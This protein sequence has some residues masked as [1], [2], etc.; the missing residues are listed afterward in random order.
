LTVKTKAYLAW[1]AISI[2]WGTTYLVIRI[3]VTEMPPY[4]FSGIRWL[5]AG[6]LFLFAL[7]LKG[8]PLPTKK[9]RLCL[10]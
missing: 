5:I 3:G 4:L 2:I 8:I 7:K 1:V 6:P 10:C 9:K